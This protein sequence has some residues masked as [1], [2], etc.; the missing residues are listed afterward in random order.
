M[1]TFTV[2]VKEVYIYDDVRAKNKQEAI[3]KVIAMDWPNHDECYR[4]LEIDVIK[5]G[6]E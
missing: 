6:E 2:K 3:D 1:K 5:G 4:P